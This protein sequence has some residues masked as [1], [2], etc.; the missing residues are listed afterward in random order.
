MASLSG[1]V[2]LVTGA[3]RGIGADVACMLA[4]EG[5]HVVC[6]A[7][8]E[9]V[10]Q[11]PLPGSLGET[12][13]RIR[14][15]GGDAIA[16]RANLARDE[17]CERVVAAARERYGPVD[18]L[19]NNAAVAFFGPTADLQVSRW[20]ASWRVTVHAMFLLSKLVAPAMID[21]GW[22]RIVNVSSESAIGPGAGPYPGSEIVGDT[23]YGAQKA[24]VE[25]FT[26]GLAQEVYPH[27]VG[28]AAI[29]PSLI[30]PTPGALANAQITGPADPRAEDPAHMPDAIRL[31]VTDPL[32]QMAGRVVY[33]QQLLE[34]HGLLTGGGG[35]GVDPSR[36]VSGYA[37]G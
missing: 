36:R 30:V 33:S 17:D 20:I 10:G 34:E 27:G 28:V 31:L 35:L 19:I 7:R 12:V 8:T 23:T 14:N 3:S 37:R 5:L 25:R 9:R 29:A 24:A 1:K 21:R 32:E 4:S 18:V 16:V 13:D 15:A 26:Q 11:H 2:G 6:C 22:G